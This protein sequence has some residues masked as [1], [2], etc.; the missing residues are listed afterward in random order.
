MTGDKTGVSC[1]IPKLT[2]LHVE[3]TIIKESNE[4]L[5]RSLKEEGDVINKRYKEMQLI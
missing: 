2:Y 5:V 3:V 1:T 4:F